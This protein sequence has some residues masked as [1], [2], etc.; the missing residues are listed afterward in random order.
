MEK[1]QQ[2]MILLP[3]IIALLAGLIAL[4]AATY[5]WFTFD[6][7]TNVTPMEGKISKGDANLLISESRDGPFDKQCDLNP[8][9]FSE[10]LRPVSTV[11]LTKFYTSIAQ[12][13]EG[14][15][16]AFQDVTDQPG[17]WLIQGTVY[18]QCLGGSCDVFFQI[19]GLEIGGD[20][21]VLAAGRLGLKITGEDGKVTTLLFQLD[22]L[23]STAGAE[24]R[25]TVQAEN[26]VIAGIDGAGAP[27]FADDPAVSIQDYRADAANPRKL[28]TLQSE[29]IA[30]VQ[31]WLYLEGCDSACFN[32]VRSRDITL[33]LGFAGEPVKE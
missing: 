17:Q 1:K 25:Q 14:Y 26:V 20:S 21:Q 31:Y 10:E 7:Y 22:S 8:T 15:S 6:P 16:V 23:G 33:Q 13:R 30:Q 18:L 19:P 29:E 12:N 32:P 2:L 3:V 9:F 5:A 28:L 4:S 11:D 27:V 24:E